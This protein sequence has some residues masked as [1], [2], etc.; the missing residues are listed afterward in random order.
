[1]SIFYHK[2]IKE[3]SSNRK[4]FFNNENYMKTGEKKKYFYAHYTLDICINTSYNSIIVPAGH[5][6]RERN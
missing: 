4:K 1:M 5:S 6:F 3:T 2:P